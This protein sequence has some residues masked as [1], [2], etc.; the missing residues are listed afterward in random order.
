[1]EIPI[2]PIAGLIAFLPPVI[3]LVYFLGILKQDFRNSLIWQ[4]LGLG[5]GF[6]LIAGLST[7]ILQSIFPVADTFL[8]KSFYTAFFWVALP[9]E[10]VKLSALLI[11]GYTA[12]KYER[13]ATYL[14]LGA[15]VSLGFAALENL[16]YV[17]ES[18]DWGGVVFT[19]AVSAVPGHAFTGILMGWFLLKV[20]TS[21]YGEYWW[22]AVLSI[23]VILH[24]AY[25]FPLMAVSEGV[26]NNIPL[27]APQM[28]IF[29][30]IGVVLL[31]GILAHI[32]ISVLPREENREE[33][34]NTHSTSL[35]TLCWIALALGCVCVSFLSFTQPT[36]IV[37]GAEV[38]GSVEYWFANGLALFTLLHGL[39]FLKAT[40]DSY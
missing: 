9:E 24:G 27:P 39:L 5:A 30:F 31:E 28:F 18:E 36:L 38:T 33:V 1:M 13:P 10:V 35:T 17:V 29:G 4:A 25:D 11:V 21:N 2:R 34:N 20:R 22:Y 40:K 16:F 32:C 37:K 14:M 7:Q 6:G 26:S 8:E 12:L 23:P 19:R 3:F 15:A